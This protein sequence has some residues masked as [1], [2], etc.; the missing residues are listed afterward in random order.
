MPAPKKI[1]KSSIN[2]SAIST[3]DGIDVRKNAS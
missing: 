3:K 1:R 2:E